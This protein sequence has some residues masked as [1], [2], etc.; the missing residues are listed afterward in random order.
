[1]ELV[2]ALQARG[3]TLRRS[4]SIEHAREHRLLLMA[5]RSGI[6][7]DIALGALP[8]DEAMISRAT[9]VSI[10][11]SKLPVP[12]PEDV[13]VMKLFAGRERDL[14]DARRIAEIHPSLDRAFILDQASQFAEAA[15]KPEIL[16]KAKGLFSS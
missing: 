7:V 8:F 14:E 6:D 2:E 4:D 9:F 13:V 15:D 10:A 16:T 1:M 11:D 3:F 5:S 12:R